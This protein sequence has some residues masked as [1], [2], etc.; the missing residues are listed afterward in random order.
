MQKMPFYSG[1]SLYPDH[2][3]Y[4]AASAF[5]FYTLVGLLNPSMIKNHRQ[6]SK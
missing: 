2:K 3:I 1:L 4:K 5:T 6:F